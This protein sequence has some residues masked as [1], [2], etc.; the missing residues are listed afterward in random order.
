MIYG[1]LVAVWRFAGLFPA[2][3]A[4]VV[5]HDEHD[6]DG[7]PLRPTTPN[8]A[9][10]SRHRSTANTLLPSNAGIRAAMA[11]ALPAGRTAGGALE[12][13]RTYAGGTARLR[14]A[15]GW[16]GDARGG[17]CTLLQPSSTRARAA[18]ALGHCHQPAP[19]AARA[20]PTGPSLAPSPSPALSACHNDA[21]IQA[22]QV[23]TVRRG[24]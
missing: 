15:R 18:L 13:A 3:T 16:A 14:R 17:L 6:T 20:V 7:G 11:D 2:T 5:S 8:Y 4:S 22:R 19:S 24:Y 12:R 1:R 10:T 21:S 23:A 9:R